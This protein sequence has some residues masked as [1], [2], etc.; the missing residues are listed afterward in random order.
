MQRAVAAGYRRHVM[1]WSWPR[2]VEAGGMKPTKPNIRTVERQ[3]QQVTEIIADAIPPELLE[4]VTV[5]GRYGKK[6]RECALDSPRVRLFL[7][8]K[9]GLR[10]DM[11][12]EE[13]KKLIEALLRSP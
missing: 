8:S 9:T 7:K 4:T 10:F 3:I 5:G 2:V 13:C 1:K 12:P 6:L 11:R